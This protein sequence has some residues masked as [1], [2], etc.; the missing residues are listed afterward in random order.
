MGKVAC[1]QWC[2][3]QVEVKSRSGL[4]LESRWQVFTVTSCDS[5]IGFDRPTFA[6]RC[7][8]A[9]TCIYTLCLLSVSRFCCCLFWGVA[10]F[11]FLADVLGNAVRCRRLLMHGAVMVFYGS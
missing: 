5:R 10:A 9:A 7:C 11:V 2:G 6:F 3:L 4:S 1:P 8:F